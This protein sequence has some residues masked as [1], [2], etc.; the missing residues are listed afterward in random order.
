MI[1]RIDLRPALILVVFALITKILLADV[2]HLK[3]WD[4]IDIL[5]QM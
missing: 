5:I 2:I 4:A 1:R 3:I